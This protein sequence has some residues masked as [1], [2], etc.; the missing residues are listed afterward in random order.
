MKVAFEGIG[1]LSKT[2]IYRLREIKRKE[3]DALMATRIQY[4]KPR[5]RHPSIW[6]EAEVEGA[7]T[8]SLESV[9]L[10]SCQ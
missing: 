10:L 2:Q 8:S 5:E 7:I 4:D 1:S 6:D 3:V 9:E